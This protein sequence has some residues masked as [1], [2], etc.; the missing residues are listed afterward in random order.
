MTQNKKQKKKGNDCSN[1]IRRWIDPFRES[2]QVC[3][4]RSKFSPVTPPSSRGRNK[5]PLWWHDDTF[6]LSYKDTGFRFFIGHIA[7]STSTSL[8][9]CIPHEIFTQKRDAHCS[10]AMSREQECCGNEGLHRC[11]VVV[12]DH[13]AMIFSRTALPLVW[14]CFHTTRLGFVCLFNHVFASAKTNSSRTGW[15]DR[16]WWGN[17]LLRWV[18]TRS[19]DAAERQRFT[20]IKNRWRRLLRPKGWPSKSQF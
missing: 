1:W 6:N 17:W 7:L 4:F 19:L 20:F 18:H 16:W 9:L 12:D 8:L 3:V 13:T 14:D 2:F 15:R 5:L 11:D 10:G